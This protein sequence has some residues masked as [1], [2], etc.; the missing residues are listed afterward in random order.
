M[1]DK[2]IFREVFNYFDRYAAGPAPGGEEAYW[3]SAAAELGQACAR[4]EGSEMG[5]DLL[6]AVFMEL[7]RRACPHPPA[8]L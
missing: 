2:A 5:R 1:T 6:C 7:E 3:L 4:L 8:V